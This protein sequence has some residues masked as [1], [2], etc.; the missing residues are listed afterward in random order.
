MWAAKMMVWNFFFG[1]RWRW[2]A[3]A[4][5][6]GDGWNFDPNVGAKKANHR[7]TR[8]GFRGGNLFFF[9]SCTSYF[10]CELNQLFSILFLFVWM[11]KKLIEIQIKANANLVWKWN[12]RRLRRKFWFFFR[13]LSVCMV[14]WFVCIVC[15]F[16]FVWMRKIIFSF[17]KKG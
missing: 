15:V 16:V 17:K 1:R 14:W 13:F 9:I 5:P 2:R 11:K 6:I 7:V 3:M 12:K 10:L 4:T 8:C